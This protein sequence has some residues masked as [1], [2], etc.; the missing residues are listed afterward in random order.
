MRI[1]NWNIE[2]MNNWFVGN[3]QVA[4][5]PSHTGIE[6]VAELAQRVANVIV[7]LDPD[8]LLI[9]EGPSSTAEMDLFLSDFLSDASGPVY[10]QLG[11]FDGGAQKIYALV[12]VDGDYQNARLVDDQSTLDLFEEF[13]VDVDGDLQLEPYDFT[14]NPLV[15]DGDLP[16]AGGTVRI[17]ALH[18]K[19]KFVNNQV[20]L[21]NNPDT[22]Q[23][24]VVAAIKNRRRISAEAMRTRQYLDQLL[25]QDADRQAVVVGDFND[26]PGVDYFERHYLTHGVADILLG[27]TYYPQRQFTHAL[28]ESVPTSQLFTA[29]FDDFIDDIANRPLLLD[30]ILVSPSLS[31][32]ASNGRIAHDEFNNQENTSRPIGARDRLPSDHRPV[33]VEID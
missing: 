1:V 23:Q 20:S 3:N 7:D 26:G 25:E 14:R 32:R 11:G 19:S 16:D 10:Q 6:D 8:V 30:H 22:R 21:W 17:V 29:V 5:R 15:I 28:V 33:V 13:L 31:A 12:H 24:F 27:N 2:W 9:E 18:T 4:W